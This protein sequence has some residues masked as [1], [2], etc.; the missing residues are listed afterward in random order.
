MESRKLTMTM[1]FLFSSL[2]I[3]LFPQA[4]TLTVVGNNSSKGFSLE[5]IHRDSVDSPLYPGGNLTSVELLQRDLVLSESR[6]LWLEEEEDES[7]ATVGRRLRD[8]NIRPTLTHAGSMYTV[9]A[10]IGSNPWTVS[11]LLLDTRS[12]LVWTQTEPCNTCFKHDGPSYRLSQSFHRLDNRHAY[13]CRPPIFHRRRRDGQCTY[14]KRY[15]GGRYTRG[16]L[17]LEQFSFGSK[18]DPT[19]K[20]IIHEVIFG[21]SY[22]N[23]R[24]MFSNNRKVLGIL[25][26]NMAEYSFVMQMASRRFSYCL[27]PGHGVNS[28]LRF[29]TDIV[30]PRG[31]VYQRTSF[32]T[33][34]LSSLNYYLPWVGISINGRA[35][36]INRPRTAFERCIIDSGASATFVIKSV[37]DAIEESFVEYYQRKH[38]RRSYIHNRPRNLRLCYDM[39]PEDSADTFPS[40]HV[41]FHFDGGATLRL[42]RIQLFYVIKEKGI[43]CLF[44]IPSKHRTLI[45]AHAQRNTHFVY[46]VSKRQLHFAPTNSCGGL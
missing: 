12:G 42:G 24:N 41:E 36:N 40:P 2:A 35:L 3:P 43:F 6:S 10:I 44:M 5:L 27:F 13:I 32:V 21:T 46:D 18:N 45:G 20:T 11:H 38:M 31:T 28:H 26:M 25:G 7:S 22:N 14:I 33:T 23:S 34:D 29:G 30:M 8:L 1:L 15:R 37:Y 17:G 19:R 9:K 39:R 16:A 4:N